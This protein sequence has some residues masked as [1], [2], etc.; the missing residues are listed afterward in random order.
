MQHTIRIIDSLKEWATKISGES[1]RWASEVFDDLTEEGKC[2]IYYRLPSTGKGPGIALCG[3]I[4]IC[5]ASIDNNR[6]DTL[7]V[8][9]INDATQR[10]PLREP[11]RYEAEFRL[12]KGTGGYAPKGDAVSHLFA[13]AKS[14]LRRRPA[15]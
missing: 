10:F 2:I 5:E 4:Y 12:A 15:A 1:S 3:D 9:Y 11:S 13:T 8:Y 14:A 7:F 6:D